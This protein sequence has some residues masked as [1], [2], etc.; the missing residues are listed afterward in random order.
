MY[1]DGNVDR[2]RSTQCHHINGRFRGMSKMRMCRGG[3]H[4]GRGPT[5][6]LGAYP[7]AISQAREHPIRRDGHLDGFNAAARHILP[8]HVSGDMDNTRL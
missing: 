5:D 8:C 1:H 2:I 4:V 7:V 3:K 6:A